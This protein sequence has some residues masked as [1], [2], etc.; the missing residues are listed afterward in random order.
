MRDTAPV[1][2]V[3]AGY[4]PGPGGAE[5]HTQRLAES[6]H[7]AGHRVCVLT[8]TAGCP[9]G[10]SGTAPLWRLP[11]PQRAP[12][13][14][15]AFASWCAASLPFLR[16]RYSIVQWVMTGLQVLPGIRLA[17]GLGMKNILML[18]GCGE[19]VR[20]Q[21]TARGRMLLKVL[22]RDLD[23]LI[24]LN[25]D[26]ESEV[27]ALGFPASRIATLPCG[28]DPD[29]FR[30]AAPVERS[31]LRARWNLPQEAA[32]ITF[33]GRFV[34]EKRLPDL[35]G[36]FGLLASRRADAKLVLVGDGA[37]RQEIAWMVE[38]SGLTPNV[39]FTG[40]LPPEKVAEV[41]R[42][43]DVYALV[44]HTE[45]IPCSL[46]EAVGCGLPCVVSDISGT[47]MVIQ[48]D[49]TGIR[50]PVSDIAR[51]SAAFEDLLADPAKRER[52]GR[53]ARAVFLQHF[54]ADRVREGYERLNSDVLRGGDS[55]S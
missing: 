3:V 47:K 33:T 16:P 38:R 23:R 41:L 50:V 46:V 7:R 24:V 17:A 18:A 20:L 8:S 19:A 45:G 28:A 44:S 32:V 29:L 2:F 1:L 5:R 30:P 21:R 31:T 36:A 12:S 42:L 43:S 4:P 48:R 14:D 11:V 40:M 25:P 15:V 55:V 6:L 26:M 9:P 34:Q 27:L 49:D 37:L 13:R 53:A 22:H 10:D 52:I 51:L 54:T 35:V 39:L